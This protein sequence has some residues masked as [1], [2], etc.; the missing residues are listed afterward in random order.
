MKAPVRHLFAGGNI[1]L[2]GARY[3]L[4]TKD[5][6]AASVGCKRCRRIEMQEAAG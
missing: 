3:R 2:C 4:L 1:A 6:D 5:Q